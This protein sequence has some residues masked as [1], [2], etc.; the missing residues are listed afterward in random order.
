MAGPRHDPTLYRDRDTVRIRRALVSVSDKTDLLVLAKA[1]A[2]A[3][4]EIVSTGSTAAAIREAGYDVTDVA[5]VTGVAVPAAMAATK[6][7][8][9]DGLVAALVDACRPLAADVDAVFL[10]QYSLA[11]A[12]PALSAAV[13]PGASRF[14]NAR[15]RQTVARAAPARIVIA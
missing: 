6:A 9:A 12:G 8:D 11:P 10:A 4:V 13:G 3:E 15:G 14:G 5:T 7:Q 1:L 2:D